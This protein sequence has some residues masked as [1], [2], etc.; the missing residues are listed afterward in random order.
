MIC[1]HPFDCTIS[2][3]FVLFQCHILEDG[4]KSHNLRETLANL[5][6]QQHWMCGICA[7]IYLRHN[8]RWIGLGKL[9]IIAIG[10][11]Y[12]NCMGAAF[13]I[14]ILTNAAVWHLASCIIQLKIKDATESFLHAHTHT[15]PAIGF[16][17]PFTLTVQTIKM[18]R[19]WKKK[20]KDT[21]SMQSLAFY[22]FEYVNVFVWCMQSTDGYF[23]SSSFLVWR[24]YYKPTNSIIILYFMRVCTKEEVRVK[25]TREDE[26]QRIKCHKDLATNQRNRIEW[27]T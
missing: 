3:L 16:F 12:S 4:G 13:A 17:F 10:Q 24:A 1:W 19:W 11:M 5:S 22:V 8:S 25:C 18:F 20:T 9:I 6:E 7:N 21:N 26:R 14:S 23:L 27:S 15:K 2:I